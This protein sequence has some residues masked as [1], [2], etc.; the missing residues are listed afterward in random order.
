MHTANYFWIEY[1]VNNSQQGE[2]Q[3]LVFQFFITRH[4]EENLNYYLLW[5]KPPKKKSKHMVT[6]V[7]RLYN[8]CVKNYLYKKWFLRSIITHLVYSKTERQKWTRI[9]SKTV[10]RVL[11][12]IWWMAPKI[13]YFLYTYSYTKV[14]KSNT[15][16][17]YIFLSLN[18]VVSKIV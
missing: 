4:F 1:Y 2:S 11:R 8:L 9:V 6:K 3:F 18:A 17:M 15:Q 14:L 12:F 5:I 13:A 7:G 10:C 16:V